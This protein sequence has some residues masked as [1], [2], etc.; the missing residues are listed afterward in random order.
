MS[1]ANASS[2]CVKV[3]MLMSAAVISAGKILAEH[4][5]LLFLMKLL[6]FLFLVPSKECVYL[7]EYLEHVSFEACIFQN[8]RYLLKSY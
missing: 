1:E 3:L 2:T 4:L 7:G 6:G 8:F 5:L